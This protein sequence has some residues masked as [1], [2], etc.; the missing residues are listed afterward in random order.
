MLGQVVVP[1]ADAKIVPS[2][3][4]ARP[5]PAP[6]PRRSNSSFEPIDPITQS[7][8]WPRIKR[9]REKQAAKVK[10]LNEYIDE[11]QAAH[12]DLRKRCKRLEV[13]GGVG[14]AIKARRMLRALVKMVHP[15][16]QGDGVAALDPGAVCGAVTE[17]LGVLGERV[18]DK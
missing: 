2:F 5:E 14:D 12:K 10:N 8:F 4:S 15:D 16:K 7:E 17:V 3:G 6:P 11:L 18:S 9:E 13:D 1:Y